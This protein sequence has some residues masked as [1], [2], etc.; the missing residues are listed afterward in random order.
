LG[1]GLVGA[2]SPRLFKQAIYEC[3]LTMIHVRNNGYI[4]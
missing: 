4:S 1:N 3:S 2:K